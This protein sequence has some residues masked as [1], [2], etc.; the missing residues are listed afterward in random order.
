M[1]EWLDNN[2]IL[3]FLDSVFL[4]GD[5]GGIFGFLEQNRGPRIPTIVDFFIVAIIP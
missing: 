2:I 5:D 1:I 3:L 4:Q